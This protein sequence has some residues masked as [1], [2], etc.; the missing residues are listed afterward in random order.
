MFRDNPL[1]DKLAAGRPALGCWLHLDC[2]AAAEVVALAGYDL[3]VI[4]HE[5]GAGTLAGAVALMQAVSATPAAPVLRVPA[6][7]AVYLK[8]ALDAGVE[9]VMIPAVDDAEAARRAVAASLYPPAGERGV[10]YPIVRASDYGLRGEAYAA[11]AN[12]NLV[13]MCQIESPRAVDNVEAIAAVAGV[14]VLFIGPFDLSAAM[15]KPGRFDDPEVVAAIARAEDAIR[16][17][18]RTMGGIARAND[19]VR[20]M[21][22]RGYGLVVGASDVTLLREGARADIAGFAAG[23]KGARP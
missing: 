6:N 3:V 20:A 16:A 22:A 4:D 21:V 23:P 10:A 5:H 15:G 14:D 17:S 19:D 13:V 1:K 7:D 9:G 18:G 11:Q 12:R 8:R 2:P